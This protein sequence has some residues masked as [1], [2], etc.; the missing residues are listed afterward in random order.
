MMPAYSVKGEE[1]EKI[2]EKIKETRIDIAKKL[3]TGYVAEPGECPCLFMAK[4][5]SG[6]DIPKCEADPKSY[7][8]ENCEGRN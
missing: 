1:L 8:V 3:A 6:E 5:D 4:L 2:L 7:M